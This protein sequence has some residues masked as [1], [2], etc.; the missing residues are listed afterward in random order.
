MQA[1]AKSAVG[2]FRRSLLRCRPVSTRT[3]SSV[4]LLGAQRF[5]PTLGS[6]VDRLGV[7]GRIALVTAGW[8]EREA[9]DDELSAHLGGQTVNLMLHARGNAVFAADPELAA[10]HRERQVLLRHLQE[11]YRIRLEHAFEAE[12]DV[13]TY[14]APE[15]IRAEVHQSSIEAIRTLDAWH[16]DHCLNVHNDFERKWH[17]GSRAEV[18]RQ[19]SEIGRVLADCSAVAI[20]GG[21]V[22]VLLNRLDL[23]DLHELLVERTVFAWSAGAMAI[24]DRVVLFH[25]D[26][27]EGRV[28]RQVL[29]VGLRLIPQAIALPEPERRLDLSANQRVALQARR[30][31]PSTCLALPA[32]SYVIWQQDRFV[33]AAGAI[34]LRDDGTT[35]DFVPSTSGSR[36]LVPST[37]PQLSSDH[38][39]PKQPGSEK[40]PG[41]KHASSPPEP[42]F[43][44]IGADEK[45]ETT[46]T[47]RRRKPHEPRSG[48]RTK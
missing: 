18:Q 43:S 40:H 20:A 36:S 2:R 34:E 21:H 35:R 26:P 23:F 10:A 27:P 9:E 28:A 42:A 39:V 6:V 48:G 13:A 11:I 29:D 33:D 24:C 22:A 37:S 44:R 19:R 38:D 4:V 46:L 25:D 41:R 45:A 30:F 7:Q 16:I 32:R 3:H 15:A 31:A 47:T 8:Q 5:E 12:R 17:T 14:D 1:A